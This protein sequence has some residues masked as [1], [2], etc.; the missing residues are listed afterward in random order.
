[1][2]NTESFCNII[3]KKAFNNE[4]MLWGRVVSTSVSKKSIPQK[5]Y[6][7]VDLKQKILLAAKTFL[8]VA[9]QLCLGFF[10]FGGQE[11]LEDSGSSIRKTYWSIKKDAASKLKSSP[12][13]FGFFHISHFEK[14]IWLHFKILLLHRSSSETFISSGCVCSNPSGGRNNGLRIRGCQEQQIANKKHIL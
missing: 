10:I 9:F 8:P 13:K 11:K 5:I 4:M 12:T 6:S 14:N 1:M 3:K 7:F 2:R